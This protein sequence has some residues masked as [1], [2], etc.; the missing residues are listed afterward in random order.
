MLTII[1]MKVTIN[2]ENTQIYYVVLI[3]GRN[4]LMEINIF[5]VVGGTFKTANPLLRGT[6]K[7]ANSL[8]RGTFETTYTLLSGTFKTA[9]SLLR[10]PH[11]LGPP[12]TKNL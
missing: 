12:S 5:R 2:S 10:G 9:N 7:T 8:L 3:I 4:T 1:I 6:F 11:F